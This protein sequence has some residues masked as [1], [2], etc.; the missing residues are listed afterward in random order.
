MVVVAIVGTLAAIAIPRFASTIRQANEGSTKGN[1][2]VM[3]SALS[4]YY[5]DH[6]GLYPSDLT[7]L[8]TPGNKYLSQPLAAYTIVH[9]KSRVVD[10]VEDAGS[11]D[12]GRWAYVNSGSNW[13]KIYIACT[14]TDT[15]G[16][17]WSQY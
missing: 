12:S 3:R 6:D 11:E 4:V 1:L 17:L 15:K 10:Y 14:H 8:L 13:G 7:P 9:D 5:A 16:N 2:G